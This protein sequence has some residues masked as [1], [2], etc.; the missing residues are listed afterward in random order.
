MPPAAGFSAATGE[1]YAGLGKSVLFD[2]DILR[3]PTF[4]IGGVEERAPGAFAS[5]A[6][7]EPE[8]PERQR[9]EGGEGG[10]VN[11]VL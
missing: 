10:L 2:P 1:P 9:L 5:A 7:V 4:D 8:E 3:A 6:A 11:M